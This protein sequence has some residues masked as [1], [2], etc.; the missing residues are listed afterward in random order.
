MFGSLTAGYELHDK[1]TL[2]SPYAR[3]D[4]ADD[5]L[6]AVSE[7]GAGIWSLNY[8][9]QNF[10]SQQVTL[11]LRSE[12]QY[13]MKFGRIVPR[14]RVE[15]QHHFNGSSQSTVAYADLIASR[16]SLTVPSASA[17]SMLVG[18]GSGFR[19]NNGLNIDLDYQ[20]WHSSDHETN[21]TILVL[22][23]KTL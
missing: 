19:L 22:F 4:Y 13:D 14:A 1:N 6:N 18:M 20:W 8:A 3:Y 16:Y 17:N 9:D 5:R 11:G 23:S 7:T 15:Y 12:L 2:L 21:Y 10:T